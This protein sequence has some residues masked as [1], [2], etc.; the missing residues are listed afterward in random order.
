MQIKKYNANKKAQLNK[1]T[2]RKQ[3][4]TTEMKK[5]NANKNFRKTVR[6]SEQI[7]SADKYPGTRQIEAIHGLFMQHFR[8]SYHGISHESLVFLGMHTLTFRRVCYC[9]HH[10]NESSLHLRLSLLST[11][12]RL[13]EKRI[14]L[15]TG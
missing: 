10:R 15:S 6:F 7:M 14:T 13:F 3:K 9:P 2:K 12:P 11:W 4:S 8:V 5:Y 1:I